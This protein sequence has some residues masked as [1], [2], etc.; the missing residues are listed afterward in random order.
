M[1]RVRAAAGKMPCP[2]PET[3]FRGVWAAS[4]KPRCHFPTIAAVA[5]AGASRREILR[6][7]ARRGAPWRESRNPACRANQNGPHERRAPACTSP[8]RRAVR[9]HAVPAKASSGVTMPGHYTERRRCP[10]RRRGPA[11]GSAA[12]RA[13][14]APGRFVAGL[15][16][17]PYGCARS[18]DLAACFLLT[19]S[20]KL[21]ETQIY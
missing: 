15:A 16:W 10:S 4:W 17:A 1:A 3:A 21:V 2:L 8:P 13:G 14:A 19:T 7:G 18:Q 6:R 11:G 12:R 5:R 20:R 9:D